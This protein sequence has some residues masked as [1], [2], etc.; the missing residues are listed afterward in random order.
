MMSVRG[1]ITHIK[2]TVQMILIILTETKN[3]NWICSIN[4]T[5]T[6]NENVTKYIII[7]EEALTLLNFIVKTCVCV[8]VCVYKYIHTYIYIN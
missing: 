1:Q 8:C 4:H 5:V 3:W 7:S 2:K 6:H